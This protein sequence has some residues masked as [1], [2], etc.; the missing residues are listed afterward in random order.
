MGDRLSLRK[1]TS[2]LLLQQEGE[3]K[4][5]CG[6]KG[7]DFVGK[8]MRSH[9]CYEANCSARGHFVR[10]EGEGRIVSAAE[11]TRKGRAYKC[12]LE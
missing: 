4:L 9:I 1:K 7:E 6:C 2:P 5:Y 8:Q 11:K 12:L 10:K 3:R